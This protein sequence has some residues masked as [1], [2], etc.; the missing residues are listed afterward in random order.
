MK[1]KVHFITIE[2]P[3]EIALGIN[4]SNKPG[5]AWVK[6]RTRYKRKQLRIINQGVEIASRIMALD[7]N[8]DE[9]NPQV[10]ETLSTFFNYDNTQRPK[11]LAYAVIDWN[12]LDEETG[13]P[14]PKPD[15]PE[16]FDELFDNQV[17]WLQA[18]INQLLKYRATEGN[19]QSGS[20]SLNG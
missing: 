19:V 14:L 7:D 11:F 16:V 2:V 5:P 1:N 6:L 20:G 17:A 12:W 3:D 18:E 10:L 13:K 4:G 9:K 15:K 8:A